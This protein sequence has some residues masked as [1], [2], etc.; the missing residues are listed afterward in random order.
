MRYEN[1]TMKKLALAITLMFAV[2]ALADN[3]KP[4]KQSKDCGSCCSA[5]NTAQAK[6]DHKAKSECS[7]CCKETPVKVALL[8]PKASAEARR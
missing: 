3:A 5:K 2:S 1:Q 7:N 6:V 8:S 4:A